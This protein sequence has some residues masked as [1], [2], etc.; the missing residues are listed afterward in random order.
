MNSALTPCV[1]AASV[2]LFASTSAYCTVGICCIYVRTYVHTYT[3]ASF[4]TEI[5]G[6]K[7]LRRYET[8]LVQDTKLRMY[9]Y[10][11]VH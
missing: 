2:F 9:I 7:K 1:T 10:T 8:K 5:K 11:F 4:M 6:P 3:L